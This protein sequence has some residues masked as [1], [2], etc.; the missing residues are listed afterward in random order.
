MWLFS[1]ESPSLSLASQVAM[2]S[3]EDFDIKPDDMTTDRDLF[4]AAVKVEDDVK[5]SNQTAVSHARVKQELIVPD[6]TLA[7]I[8]KLSEELYGFL[9]PVEQITVDSLSLK[10][11]HEEGRA[12][13]CFLHKPPPMGIWQC[14]RV[15]LLTKL[16]H[17]H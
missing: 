5:P 3:Q 4:L 13:P 8:D 2:S 12:L 6:E 1:S 7:L 11:E 10:M 15:C 9:P 17:F 16:I 14:M